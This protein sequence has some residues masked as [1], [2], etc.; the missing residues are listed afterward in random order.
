MKSYSI[1]T[2]TLFLWL[3]AGCSN[4]PK[5]TY[6]I[7]GKVT[8]PALDGRTV[9]IQDALVGNIR[10]DSAVVTH[11]IFRFDGTQSEPVIREFFIQEND[12]D[13]FPVTLPFVLEPGRIE[14]DLGERVYVG[15]TPLNKEMMDVL[16]AID[17]FRDQDFTGSTI[18]DINSAFVT[19]IIE[20][21][22]KHS[23]N[24]IGKYLFDAYQ[25]KLTEDQKTQVRKTLGI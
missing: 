20:Q 13:L 18:E 1:F 7:E 6:T 19:C 11:G 21:I 15:N 22:V 2:A 12:S 10:Y 8:L 4:A 5:A 3:A 24:L 25:S 17:H 16:M 14:A 9:Y 23:N